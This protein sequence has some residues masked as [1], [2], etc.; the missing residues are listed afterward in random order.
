MIEILPDESDDLTYI[1][2]VEHI[3]NGCAHEYKPAGF[4]LVRVKGWFDH[5]WLGF[6]GK[7]QGQLPVWNKTLTLPPFN[8]SRVLSQRFY[9]WSPRDEGYVRST[10]WAR[11]HRHQQSSDNLKRYVRRVGGSVALAWFCD[12]TLQSGQGSLMIYIRT[13]REVNGWFI[14]LDRQGDVW[15]KRFDNVSLEQAEKLEQV[16]R[17]LE[18]SES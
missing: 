8:P 14:S 16:G 6:A 2:T 5:K 1:K 13:P 7:V 17:Q 11:L 4:Y 3:V 12:D 15:R 10:G 9:V 18:S